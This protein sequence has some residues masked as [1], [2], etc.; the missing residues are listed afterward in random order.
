MLESSNDSPC[1]TLKNEDHRAQH[2]VGAEP[3]YGW[4]PQWSA[5]SRRGGSTFGVQHNLHD[6]GIAYSQQHPFLGSPVPI[7]EHYTSHRRR[8][9]SIH[10]PPF[11]R[12]VM[13]YMAKALNMV[14]GLADTGIFR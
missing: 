13:E 7:R 14:R 11:E 8:C 4:L 10:H 6:V 2:A 5:I 1:D 9:F 12:E 3:L